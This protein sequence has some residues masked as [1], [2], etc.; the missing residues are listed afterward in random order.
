MSDADLAFADLHADLFEVFGQDGTVQRGGDAA[1]PVRV[2][3]DRGVERYGTNGEVVATVTVVSFMVAQW[4]PSA[5][6]VVAVG[7]WSKKVDVLDSDDGYVAKAV[8]YG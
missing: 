8:M 7:A 2:V 6:D 5:G 4:M 3:I 1:V